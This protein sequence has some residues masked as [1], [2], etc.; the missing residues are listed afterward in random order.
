[1]MNICA[2]VVLFQALAALMPAQIPGMLLGALE[3]VTGMAAPGPP[4]PHTPAGTRARSCRRTP[5]AAPPPAGR[6]T[7]AEYLH[8]FAEQ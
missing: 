7:A 3:M 6:E 8:S 5:A 2:F 1:M 4:R